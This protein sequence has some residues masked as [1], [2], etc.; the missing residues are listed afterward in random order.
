MTEKIAR[1]ESANMRREAAKQ[2]KKVR[3]AIAASQP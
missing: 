2:R 1:R 3:T